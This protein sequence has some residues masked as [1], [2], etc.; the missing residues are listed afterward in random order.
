MK[1]WDC[2]NTGKWH[3]IECMDK[4]SHRSAAVWS[5]LQDLP[6]Q[7]VRKGVEK[8]KSY[9][10]DLNSID[11]V[12]GF[13]KAIEVFDG[14]F[15]LA[16]GRYVIDAKSIM[17]IFSMDLSKPVEFRVLETHEKLSAIEAA[18]APYIAKE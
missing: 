2:T 18:V 15:D 7:T 3:K 12:K 11:R 5:K 9:M 8:M 14:Y 17:G 10:L 13:V 1:T 6:Q 16:T 4:I